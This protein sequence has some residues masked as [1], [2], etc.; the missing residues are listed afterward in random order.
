[1]SAEV[2]SFY[3]NNNLINLLNSQ[4]II[5]NVID[6]YN[7][8]SAKMLEEYKEL[9]SK[10]ESK[11]NDNII[12]GLSIDFIILHIKL[13]ELKSR[14]RKLKKKEQQF[15]KLSSR[16]AFQ[17]K[18]VSNKTKKV[19][20]KEGCSICFD[21]H[22]IKYMFTTKCKHHF[23]DCCFGKYV[24]HKLE[25]SNNINCPLCRNNNILPVVKYC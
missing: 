2:E 15:Y 25:N 7:V 17:I 12:H 10:P 20:E 9:R 13:N 16:G 19:I 21:N 18:K 4:D 8:K 22:K 5:D 14:L 3:E 1:M 23:G 24:E 11:Q 6:Y